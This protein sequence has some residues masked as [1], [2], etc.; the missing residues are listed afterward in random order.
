MLNN[1]IYNIIHVTI[2]NDSILYSSRPILLFPAIGVI[3]SN[4][5]HMYLECLNS[6][7]WMHHIITSI[8]GARCNI[9]YHIWFLSAYASWMNWRLHS[10]GWEFVLLK[11]SKYN[12][13]NII[14]TL[15]WVINMNYYLHRGHGWSYYSYGQFTCMGDIQSGDSLS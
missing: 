13:W 7:I 10:I 1:I 4:A 2:W 14:E 8:S 12:L 9:I 11:L 5:R 6:L 3:I 15:A